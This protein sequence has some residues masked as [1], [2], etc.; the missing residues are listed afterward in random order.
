MAAAELRIGAESEAAMERLA[1]FKGV[2][3]ANLRTLLS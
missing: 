3:S 2:M 1:N